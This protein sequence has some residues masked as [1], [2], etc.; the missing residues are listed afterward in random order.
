MYWKFIEHKD[1]DIVNGQISGGIYVYKCSECGHIT[2]VTRFR[3]LKSCEC[4]KSEYNAV[5]EKAVRK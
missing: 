3:D 2:E 5:A 4:G 1:Y